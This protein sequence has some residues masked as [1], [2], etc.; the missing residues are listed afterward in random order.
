MLLS[1]GLAAAL[2]FYAALADGQSH[3]FYTFLRLYVC[4]LSLFLAYAFHIVNRP[5]LALGALCS[6]ILFNPVFPVDLE[7]DDWTIIDFI[8]GTVFAWIGLQPYARATG[9]K[10]APYAP[11]AAA[12]ALV[13]FSIKPN[14]SYADDNTM[15]VD[16]LAVDN[17]V[18]ND[19][20]LMEPTADTTTGY[21]ANMTV[22][23]AGT[24][25]EAGSSIE[26]VANT[27]EQS[28]RTRPP[29]VWD[30]MGTT[31]PDEP[32][33]AEAA[34]SPSEDTSSDSDETTEDEPSDGTE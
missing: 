4:G 24:L 34:P 14:P 16:N 11:G 23:S 17:L 27:L 19:T 1:C 3:G 29:S 8:A 33:E 26:N 21:D 22:N 9:R 10:W 32:A 2:L 6:A 31:A 7:R 25:E 28:D 18:V 12:L 20:T 15:N 5:A 30:R 13:L